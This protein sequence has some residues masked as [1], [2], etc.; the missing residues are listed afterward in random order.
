MDASTPIHD[1]IPRINTAKDTELESPIKAFNLEGNDLIVGEILDNSGVSDDHSVYEG[2][3]KNLRT[4]VSN[5]L[6]GSRIDHSKH[7]DNYSLEY[8]VGASNFEGVA[9]MSGILNESGAAIL[10][11]N[12]NPTNGDNGEVADMTGNI[13]LPA[14]GHFKE[15]KKDVKSNVNIEIANE[16]AEIF[17][18]Q[19]SEANIS[20]W[21]SSSS[22][23]GSGRDTTNIVVDESPVNDG[24]RAVDPDL[25]LPKLF[26]EMDQ[27][28]ANMDIVGPVDQIVR[29]GGAKLC[30]IDQ[31]GRGGTLNGA[32]LVQDP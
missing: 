25:G 24:C 6:R 18:R 4:D 12:I 1:S 16:E 7:R 30:P 2:I 28:E 10:V 3:S 21:N 27:N 11:E 9:I 29:G 23:S 19:T 15:A 32:T 14:T 31:I 17:Q 13:S 5:E 8:A 26:G 22:F 20:E